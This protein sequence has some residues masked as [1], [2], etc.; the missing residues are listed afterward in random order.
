MK[1]LVKAKP[2]AREESIVKIDETTFAVS[3]KEP[4]TEGR[5]NEAIVKILA[6]YFS[7]PAWRVNIVSGRKS[8]NKI[9]EIGE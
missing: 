1:I 5:A 2:G 3:V 6:G 9:I 4:P 7:V 8:Q